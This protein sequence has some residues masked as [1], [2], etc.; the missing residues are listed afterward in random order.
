VGASVALIRGPAAPTKPLG[1]QRGFATGEPREAVH[2]LAFLPDNKTLA[3]AHLNEVRLWDVGAGKQFAAS[4]EPFGGPPSRMVFSPDGKRA[5]WPDIIQG[6]VLRDPLKGKEI[7]TL[8]KRHD[9]FYPVIFSPNGKTL[10]TWEGGVRIWELATLQ[11]RCLLP[12]NDRPVVTI[13]LAV[14]PDDRM[15]ASSHKHIHLWD[16]ATGRE[17][18]RLVG[19]ARG[20]KCLAFSHDGSRLASGTKDYECLVW[21]LKA[22]ERVP[23]PSA[24]AASSQELESI[25]AELAKVDSPRAFKA[26]SR[27]VTYSNEAVTFIGKRLQPAPKVPGHIPQLIRDLDS[28]ESAIRER[29]AAE[30]EQLGDWVKPA[31]QAALQGNPSSELR[32]Q[33]DKLLA[34]V[35]PVTV[36]PEYLR[37]CR[38]LEVLEFIGTAEA[39]RVLEVLAQG[40]PEARLTRDAKATLERLSKKKSNP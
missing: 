36:P 33:I 11:E 10:I 5:V 19:H 27:L 26:L 37:D 17:I 15:L 28:D 12:H 29:A 2:G 34:K 21:D 13:S 38:A 8:D 23:M 25:W 39:R 7:E 30:L 31:L 16:L 1:K 22:M 9:P 18:G 6:L 40:A 3:T 14:S 24:P 20:A 32:A 35:P 4:K